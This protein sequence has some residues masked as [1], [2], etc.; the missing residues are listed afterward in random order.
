[1]GLGFSTTGWL[2][3]LTTEC[4]AIRLVSQLP[5]STALPPGPYRAMRSVPPTEPYGFPLPDGILPGLDEKN[6]LLS[7]R[8]GITGVDPSLRTNYSYNWFFGLQYGL[9]RD[10]V[11]Q[12][13]YIGSSAHKLYSLYDVNRFNGDLLV[14]NG[15]LQR[16]NRS[17]GGITY[18]QNVFNSYYTGGT[19]AV[20]KRFSSGFSVDSAYT[21][22]RAIDGGFVGGG[23][24]EVDTRVADINNLRRERG[25]AVFDIPQRWTLSILYQ[26]PQ[27]APGPA[28]SMPC[29]EAGNSVMS[30]SS[31]VALLSAYFVVCLFSR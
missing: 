8:A 25:L 10:W 23:G 19:F 12:A 6:G 4:K 29:S 16:L 9:G 22:G 11:L 1:M 2:Q 30:L 24:N 3:V 7:A 5:R 27:L 26:V 17:F 14:N 31:K 20:K 21:I 13:N 18:V 15:V 28:S